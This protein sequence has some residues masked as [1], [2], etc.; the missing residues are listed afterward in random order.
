MGLGKTIQIISLLL[1]LYGKTGKA[2]V[3]NVQNRLRKKGALGL[4]STNEDGVAPTVLSDRR[5]RYPSLIVAPKSLVGNWGVELK[6]WGYILV[7]TMGGKEGG[8]AAEKDVA[9]NVL[10]QAREAKIEVVVCTYRGLVTHCEALAAIRWNCIIFDEGHELKNEHSQRHVAAMKLEHANF[11]VILS[12]TPIQ[13][14]L[15]ELWALLTVVTHGRFNEKS[16][17]KS[18]FAIPIKRAR[19]RSAPP[20]IVQLGERRGKELQDVVMKKYVLQRFKDDVLGHELKGKTDFVVF[21]ELAPVQRKLYEHV[22]SLPDVDNARYV[23]QPCECGS[24]LKRS[25][26]CQEKFRIPYKRQR[27]ETGT[28]RAAEEIDSRAVIWRQLHPDNEP[29]E[30]C[31]SCVILPCLSK[32]LKVVSHPAL[33]Q[34]AAVPVPPHDP[35]YSREQA[36][37]QFYSE[38]L[39]SDLQVELGGPRRCSDFLTCSRVESSGKMKTLDKLLTAFTRRSD[40]VLVFSQSTQTLDILEGFVKGRGWRHLRLD[41]TTPQS[42]RQ[43]LVDLFNRDDAVLVFLISTKAG[44]LGLNLTS[45]NKVIIFDCNWNPS[46]DMQAQDRAYRFGQQRPVS[47]YRLVA[48]GTVEEVCYMRQVYKQALQQAAC[49]QRGDVAGVGLVS[50]AGSGRVFEGV[51]GDSESRGELFGLENLL[52]CEPDG[53]S[54]L[55]KLRRKYEVPQAGEGAS[56]GNTTAVRSV[57]RAPEGVNT[58]RGE[59]AEQV[60]ARFARDSGHE[61]VR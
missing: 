49:A 40:K 23:M 27:L 55:A 6:R 33:L 5:L 15:E 60:V 29:C 53:G 56:G 10:S 1:A 21:C 30:K 8:R 38:A 58:I 32:L 44:G 28:S 36:V 17:F 16:S 31:P 54:I 7:A 52:Q 4:N 35:R 37:L 20:G 2:A 34:A 3:D 51:E 59:D 45:A 14:K 39:P 12:G 22:L 47:V 43:S 46:L 57:G 25:R 61:L 18:H 42:A 24:E 41:G 26:C 50:G 11:R 13:N 9:D 48:Q 19:K